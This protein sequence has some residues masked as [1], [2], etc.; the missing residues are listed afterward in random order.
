[1][2]KSNT[3]ILSVSL[4]LSAGLYG[5]STIK[6]AEENKNIKESKS[7]EKSPAFELTIAH[8]NDTH[9]SFD[10]LPS[11]FL[12]QEETIFNEFGGHPRLLT[13]AEE[14]KQSARNNNQSMLFLHGG[15]AWQG[16]AYFK[17][18]EGR[19]NADILSQLGLDAMALGNHEFD[20][21]NAHLNEFLNTINFPV[22]A[23]NIDISKDSDLKDQTNLL[24]YVLFEFKG[25]QKTRLSAKDIQQRSPFLSN[26][27]IVAVIGIALDNMPDIS[28][29]TGN[30][31]FFDMT[32]SAQATVDQL[33]QQGVN[34]VIALTHIGTSQDKQLAAQVNGIDV[35]VGGHSHTLL[36]DFV[37]LGLQ[38][39]GSYAQHIIN[40]NQTSYTC[41][42]QAGAYAQAIGRLQ[43]SFNHNGEL[44][45]CQG[46]N[47]LLSND[48]FYSHTK[49]IN[50]HRTAKHRVSDEKARQIKRFI[51]SRDAIDITAEHVE[52]RQYI[53]AHYKPTVDRAYGQPI[54]Y[55]PD[56]LQ[57]GR[58]PG[59]KGTH[60][61]HGSAVAQLVGEGFYYWA[62]KPE[63]IAV[64]G[65]KPD[66][67]LLGAGGVRT[68]INQGK[69]REGHIRL[70]LLPFANALSIV[71]L[72]KAEITDLLE[73]VIN[74]TLAEGSHA[75][76]FPYSGH[77]RY[78]FIETQPG[79]RGSITQLERNIGS[80]EQ[81]IWQPLQ[82]NIRYNVVMSAYNASGN[83]GWSVLYH[84][85]KKRTDRV[86]LAYVND[87]LSAFPVSRVVRHGDKLKTQYQVTAL[88][89]KA[90]DIRCDT[91]A[92]AVID[93]ISQV[94]TSLRPLPYPLVYI[95]RKNT[96]E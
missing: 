41:I 96:T 94:R 9:S 33:H 76:K 92:Q 66:F 3:L 8:I 10:P 89:C 6:N 73:S 72:S 70:E 60:P 31:E 19:A 1:M 54:A 79:L 27:N 57:H 44:H 11:S 43:V 87:T 38:N 49:R 26:N 78:T 25:N 4:I 40:P 20:L 65:L 61:I 21:S 83:D 30:V 7:T 29:A 62:S 71:P 18:N 50:Q 5:C 42:V 91:D 77:L 81:P 55:V 51:E 13:K 2:K 39:E 22:V 12:M 56:T 69:L 28:T 16:S 84:A 35:I 14:Y 93:F 86:D 48:D 17:L 95:K 80:L 37:D 74:A 68:H 64:S 63:V 32:E 23:A 15:D 85:Q 82:D 52:L 67:A 46:G 88:N 59:E 58:R 90:A 75:G 36:G 34:K 47:M 53:N 45:Q 24:P